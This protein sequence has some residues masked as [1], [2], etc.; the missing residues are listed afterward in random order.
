M[1]I[2]L[3][4]FLISIIFFMLIWMILALLNVVSNNEEKIIIP[5]FVTAIIIGSLFV[6]NNYKNRE[7]RER[8][9]NTTE[10]NI[11]SI[12]RISSIEGNFVLGTGGISEKQNYIFYI[13]KE[14]KAKVL[15]KIE[16]YG[17]EVFEGDYS[18]KIVKTECIPSIE[19]DWGI[20]TTLPNYSSCWDYK[21]KYQIYVPKNTII[22]NMK[23]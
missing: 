8:S 11:Y 2:F 1:V 4:V 13:Q 5:I 10:F 16:A 9:F 17:T 19:F 18:P 14:N 20:G 7:L 15:S 22:K 23:L 12:E 6:Y 21:D 3:G